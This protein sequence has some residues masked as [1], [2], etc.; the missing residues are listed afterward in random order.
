MS[1]RVHILW[2]SL[3]IVFCLIF[4]NAWAV[5]DEDLARLGKDLTPIGAEKAGNEK[6]TIPAWEGGLTTPPA[7]YVPGEYRVDPYTEDKVLFTIT[8]DN[9]DQYGDNLTQSHKEML[10]RYSTFRMNIYPTRRSAGYPERIYE[11]TKLYAKGAQMDP[12]GGF[13]NIVQGIPFPIPASGAEV[14]ANYLARYRGESSKKTYH[15]LVVQ[16]NGSYTPVKMSEVFYNKYHLPD[17]TL[18]QLDFILYYKQYVHA[19]PRLAGQIVL[20]HEPTS[21]SD[22]DRTVW[23]YNPGQRRVRRAPNY[24]HD[25][26][27]TGSDGLF[28]VDQKNQWSGKTERYDWTLIGKK[29]M[30]VPYNDY[31]SVTDKVKLKDLIRPLHLNP[32]H[33][34]Y[35]LHRVWI[36]DAT[37][38]EGA[39][40]LYKK[41]RYYF[42]ED[43]WHPL[44][45]DIYDNE[46][47]FWRFTES[48]CMSYYDVPTFMMAY[49]THMDLLSKRYNVS[50]LVNETEPIDFT[51]KFD[52]KEFTTSAI[53][54]EGRR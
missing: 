44:V 43:S 16:E 21:Y 53:R 17:M 12:L 39:K 11:T 8:A 33:L 42:D 32:D 4:S 23:T 38:K 29:E 36:V 19:P 49:E 24:E 5:T 40:H 35:E 27:G 54:M 51:V 15:Q 9:M 46:D 7:N 37:L 26:P 3:L 28:T 47:K 6:G 14:M 22:Y 34:R 50:Q 20:L 31:A 10:K 41:R 13:R 30:Y 25:N 52:L 48:H 2:I 1:Y 45:Q 18:D